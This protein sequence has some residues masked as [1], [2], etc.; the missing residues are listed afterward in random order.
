M[1]VERWARPLLMLDLDLVLWRYVVCV[2]KVT[3][4]V[5][6]SY[7]LD[8]SCDVCKFAGGFKV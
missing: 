2:C 3:C 6:I 8:V 1:S 5:L 4:F 7:G